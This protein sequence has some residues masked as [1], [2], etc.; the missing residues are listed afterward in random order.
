MFWASQH[1]LYEEWHLSSRICICTDYSMLLLLLWAIVTLVI[2]LSALSFYR[3]LQ[4]WVNIFIWLDRIW[5]LQPLSIW[6]IC[7]ILKF[8]S[9]SANKWAYVWLMHECEEFTTLLSVILTEQILRVKQSKG[10]TLR[11]WKS[12]LFL[13]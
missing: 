11:A 3:Y 2:I 6:V 1:A 10:E 4:I 7:I 8:R 12:L 5:Q 9:L 13:N